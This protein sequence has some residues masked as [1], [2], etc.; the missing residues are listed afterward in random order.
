M[1]D[2]RFTPKSRRAQSLAQ[3]EGF[4]STRPSSQQR[5]QDLHAIPLPFTSIAPSAD[6]RTASPVGVA[7]IGYSLR[8]L[9]TTWPLAAL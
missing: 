1:L 8:R 9:A 7:E 3:Q 4:M 5:L 2:V 6:R